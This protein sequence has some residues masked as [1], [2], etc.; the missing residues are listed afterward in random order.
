MLRH[1][2]TTLGGRRRGHSGDT[3]D[4]DR[5]LA[6]TEGDLADIGLRRGDVEAWGRDQAG[7]LH[8][9]LA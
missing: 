2:R 3:S 5:L 7:R 6:M 9:R 8:R 4:L 1:L